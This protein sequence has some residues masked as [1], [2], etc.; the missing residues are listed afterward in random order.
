M[1]YLLITLICLIAFNASAQDVIYDYLAVDQRLQINEITTTERN[2]LSSPVAWTI[3]AN[4]TTGDLE[5]WNGSS[6]VSLTSAA[7]GTEFADDVFRI[8]DN[9]DATKELAWQISGIT[10]GTTRT[11]TPANENMN[12]TIGPGGSYLSS[13]YADYNSTDDIVSS[14]RIL[15]NDT[16]GGD[17]QY[18]TLQ[19]VLLKT[20]YNALSTATPSTSS[21]VPYSD[22]T[23]LKVTTTPVFLVGAYAAETSFDLDIDKVAV[24]DNGTMKS[25][26]LEE[27]LFQH[28]TLS[29]GATVS[30]DVSL[31]CSA[32]VTLAGNRTL[33]APTNA[34]AGMSGNLKVIQDGTG[35]RTL[36]YNAVWKWEG[37]TAPTLTTTASAVDIISWWTDGTNFYAAILQD[38]Q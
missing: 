36:A 13:T 31:G 18:D 28:Q 22:G 4:S 8:Q 26:L 20:V 16:S 14:D 24:W 7:G 30:W 11:I 17:W 34:I 3:V 29:D 25:A 9:A 10:T 23:S 15:W 32:Q 27:L 38:L 2:A 19:E 5:V 37:G 35:S 1:R 33:G 6:W 12:L 21:Y